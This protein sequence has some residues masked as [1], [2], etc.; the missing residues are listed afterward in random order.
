[1]GNSG[2][3]AVKEL[4]QSI[5]AIIVVGGTGYAFIFVPSQHADV[6]ATALGTVLGFYFAKQIG[7]GGGPKQ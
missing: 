2:L 7:N 3:D 4:T 5:L 6:L 1:M